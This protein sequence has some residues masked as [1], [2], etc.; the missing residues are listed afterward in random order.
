MAE[1]FCC[2]KRCLENQGRGSCPR[3]PGPIKSQPVI[4]TA[5]FVWTGVIL[6]VIGMASGIVWLAKVLAA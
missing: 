2:D 4:G 3:Y 5:P 6:L 1:R